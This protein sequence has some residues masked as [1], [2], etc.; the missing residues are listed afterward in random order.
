MI[1]KT[2]HIKMLWLYFKYC[3]DTSYQAAVGVILHDRSLWQA[4]NISKTS[5]SNLIVYMQTI[6][7]GFYIA[8]YFHLSCRIG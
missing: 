7:R 2:T 5:S 4:F 1:L 8:C 3:K 6:K